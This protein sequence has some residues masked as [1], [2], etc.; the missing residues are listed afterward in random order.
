MI[1]EIDARIRRALA[2]IRQTFRGVIRLVKAAGAVQLVQVDGLAGEMLQD[3][4]LFQHYGFTSNPLPGTMAVIVPVGGKTSHGIVV[5][6]E[7]GTYRKK[8][9]VSGEVALYTDEGDYVLLS[10]GRII[11]VVAGAQLEVTAP[12]VTI[13]ASTKV[14]METPLLEVTGEIKDR[15]DSTGKTMAGMRTTYDSH[16]HH[17]NDVNGETNQPT[18]AM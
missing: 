10:R 6:T 4:E 5:A 18:Q 8:N 16:T 15:C 12:L 17:E 13:K 2:G 9:L 3:A 11:K 7:H 1:R 14:R